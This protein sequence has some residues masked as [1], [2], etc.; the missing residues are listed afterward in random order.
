MDGE[1]TYEDRCGGDE[2]I[3]LCRKGWYLQVSTIHCEGLG[4]SADT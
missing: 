3:E 1:I 4:S 2:E